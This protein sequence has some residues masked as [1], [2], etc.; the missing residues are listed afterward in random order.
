MAAFAGAPVVYSNC[1][2]PSM[3]PRLWPGT[4]HRGLWRC[5]VLLYMRVS[6]VVASSTH[7]AGA[8]HELGRVGG[9]ERRVGARG[10]LGGVGP[11]E[12][13]VAHLVTTMAAVMTMS[14][15]IVAR[16]WRRVARGEDRCSRWPCDDHERNRSLAQTRAWSAARV[17][18]RG[19]HNRNRLW[20]APRG[21]RAREARG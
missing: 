8:E 18:Y 21:G 19:S 14:I 16:A 4:A 12:A 7:F 3:S 9:A 1:T 17:E 20:R 13:R 11:V 15:T 10:A 2:H 6:G 5:S